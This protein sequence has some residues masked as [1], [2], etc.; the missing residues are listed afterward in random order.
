MNLQLESPSIK[1]SNIG[2]ETEAAFKSADVYLW[3]GDG[4]GH[5]FSRFT[6]N[7]FYLVDVKSNQKVYYRKIEFQNG[8]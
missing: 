5:D 6:G 1:I 3:I 7:D 8:K 2:Y 4:G